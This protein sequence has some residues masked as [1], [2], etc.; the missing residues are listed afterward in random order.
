MKKALIL[1]VALAG[2]ALAHHGQAAYDMTT[3]VT[4]QGT[5]TEFHFTNPHCV[6]EMDVKDDKGQVQTWQGELTSASRLGRSGWTPASLKAGDE[7]TVTGYRARSGALS[8]WITKVVGSNGQ[9]LK[10]EAGN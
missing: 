9:E 3:R 5:I 10:I 4:V 7:V 8:L 6:L 2:L 1:L